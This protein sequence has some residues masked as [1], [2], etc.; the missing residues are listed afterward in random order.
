MNEKNPHY[1]SLDDSIKQVLSDDEQKALKQG[2]EDM[3][4]ETDPMM[5]TVATYYAGEALKYIKELE[6]AL[7]K[8]KWKHR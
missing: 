8:L 5:P 6:D 1:I 4:G 7:G 3:A 2:L